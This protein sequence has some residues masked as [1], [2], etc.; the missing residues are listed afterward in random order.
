MEARISIVTTGEGCLY[1]PRREMK[2]TVNTKLGVSQPVPCPPAPSPP[3][4]NTLLKSLRS[5]VC[6]HT[7]DQRLRQ[8]MA[9]ITDCA[10]NMTLLRASEI[11]SFCKFNDPHITHLVFPPNTC[12]ARKHKP[13][14]QFVVRTYSSAEFRYHLA[15][16]Q[17]RPTRLCGYAV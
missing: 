6:P 7:P 4:R 3:W 11:K 5:S 8:V 14:P 1:S 15:A 16:Y 12:R 17:A 10:T 13:T 9:Y 2:K